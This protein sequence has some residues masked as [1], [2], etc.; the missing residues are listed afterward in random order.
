MFYSNQ[1]IKISVKP[2]PQ[3][4]YVFTEAHIYLS[5][6]N[7]VPGH[8]IFSPF[9]NLLSLCYIELKSFNNNFQ[10]LIFTNNFLFPIPNLQLYTNP[11][12]NTNSSSNINLPH[13]SEELC[14]NKFFKKH[15]KYY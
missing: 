4:D 11:N 14:Y 5:Y 2:H 3:L 9:G 13:S 10:I 7:L 6:E 1:Y 8:F 15:R 12:L